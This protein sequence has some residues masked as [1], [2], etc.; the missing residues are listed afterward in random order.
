M[1]RACS[2]A[3][4]CGRGP[5]FGP[6]EGAWS[7]RGYSDPGAVVLAA[8]GRWA[9]G[10]VCAQSG[11]SEEA[12]TA[13]RDAV[14]LSEGVSLYHVMLAYGLAVA[15]EWDEAHDV[16]RSQPRFQALVRRIG[17]PSAIAEMP[18]A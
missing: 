15:G 7:D 6:A 16:L 12:V 14:R 5:A 17:P 4:A 8:V 9:H 13:F 11:H 18:G 3:S 1:G 2:R 10:L